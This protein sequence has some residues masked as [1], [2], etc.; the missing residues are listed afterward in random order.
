MNDR[1]VTSS[2]GTGQKIESFLKG[3]RE[4][5]PDD[6]GE[7]YGSGF[8]LLTAT[9]LKHDGGKSST[10]MTLLDDDPGDAA[11]R[12]AGVSILVFPIR[13]ASGIH[14]HM[15]TVG[16]TSKNDVVVP[17]IS[18][19]RFHA[20]FKQ[21]ADGVWQVLDA[22]STNGTMVNGF[23]VPAKGAGAPIDLKA[24]DSVR[25]GQMDVT[26]LDA[27]ALRAFALKFDK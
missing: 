12:T 17:D 4:L 22:G 13:P 18:I 3:A 20:Y 10:E 9:G 7:H 27:N 26:F 5:T 2:K 8:L 19:S 1:V 16:R 11:E 24:G 23:S 6:F 15:V 25:L 21:K 14:T